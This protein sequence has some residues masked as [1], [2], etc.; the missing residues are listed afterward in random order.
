MFRKWEACSSNEAIEE[1]TPVSALAL[2]GRQWTI[3]KL[4]ISSSLTIGEE[5]LAGLGEGVGE[6]TGLSSTLSNSSCADGRL[7]VT[8]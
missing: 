5:T 7:V 2:C 8:S 6:L 3:L 4:W 1:K